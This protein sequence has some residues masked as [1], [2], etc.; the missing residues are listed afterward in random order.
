MLLLLLL[1]QR[2]H[3]RCYLL[4]RRD[5]A[6][7]VR[8]YRLHHPND[9]FISTYAHDVEG[10]A[11]DPLTGSRPGTLAIAQ[12]FTVSR[13]LTDLAHNT[14]RA[15][16]AIV[17]HVFAILTDTVAGVKRHAMTVVW[18]QVACLA[19]AVASLLL[20]L[21]SLVGIAIAA[22]SRT[23]EERIIFRSAFHA[24]SAAAVAYCAL[25]YLLLL[26]TCVA[27][28]AFARRGEY[29]TEVALT[30]SRLRQAP[31][32]LVAT[33]A[34]MMVSASTHDGDYEGLRAALLR[35]LEQQ[36]EAFRARQFTKGPAVGMCRHADALL[37][38]SQEPY[39]SFDP[40]SSSALRPLTCVDP[41]SAAGG[42]GGN[43]RPHAIQTAMLSDVL[44]AI[45]H[46]PAATV[47]RGGA[48]DGLDGLV[49]AALSRLGPIQFFT[50]ATTTVSM[51]DTA[52]PMLQQGWCGGHLPVVVSLLTAALALS[53]FMYACLLRRVQYDTRRLSIGTKV[54]LLGMPPDVLNTIQEIHAFYDPESGS[55][56]E[57]A[58]WRAQES[59]R[60][61]QNILPLGISRRFK[62]G[63]RVIADAHACVTVVF[64]GI[65]GID[66]YC[67][68]L[69]GAQLVR[70]MNCIVVAFD[71]IVDLLGL[72]KIKLVGEIYF[73][74]GGLTRIT[75]RDHALR[76]AEASL[77]FFQSLEDHSSRHGIPGIRLKIGIHTGAVVAGV[78][79]NK[80]VAYNLWGDCV[81][82]ASR[83]YSTSEQG[84]LQVSDATYAHV[85]R[86]HAFESREVQVKGKGSMAT[87]LYLDRLRGTAYSEMNW[88]V[89]S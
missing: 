44:R 6:A 11:V 35:G 68:T 52:P 60:L 75:A 50:Y 82:T 72:E 80:K 43:Q 64:A 5:A 26:A 22:Q 79:G 47:Q 49:D 23:V 8:R 24:R 85:S 29:C 17:V 31:D 33:A 59:E 21:F 36:P 58:K 61:L 55:S 45:A 18:C 69:T 14:T 41:I 19:A 56:G 4:R 62:N 63:K 3:C 76:C 13:L 37:F 2:R 32:V 53:A 46:L 70:F 87:H 74:C 25:V 9:V 71:R 30:L 40:L 34:A 38:G 28:V 83:M 57:Q 7:L 81:N 66:A 16:R 12:G 48:G 89:S 15:H 1:R 51:A 77:F 27:G 42:G 65:E 39:A 84:R 10:Q 88:R 78:I 86:Y 20:L 67:R 73:F 54:M